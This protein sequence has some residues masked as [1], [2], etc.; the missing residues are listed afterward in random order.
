MSSAPEKSECAESEDHAGQN[1]VMMRQGQPMMRPIQRRSP[2]SFINSFSL[3][4]LRGC[5]RNASS[6]RCI[7]LYLHRTPNSDVYRH[8]PLVALFQQLTLQGPVHSEQKRGGGILINW[9]IISTKQIITRYIRKAAIIGNK[10]SIKLPPKVLNYL[11][12]TI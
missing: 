5:V 1:G 11:A 9:K 7:Y 8:R 10:V 2:R 4:R 6:V 12:Y 3:L